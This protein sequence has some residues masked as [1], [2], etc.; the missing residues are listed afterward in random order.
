MK[1]K[2]Y[3]IF[4]GLAACLAGI[5]LLGQVSR[6]SEESQIV[7][8]NRQ[9]EDNMTEQEELK[10]IYRQVNQAMVDKDTAGLK[11]LLKEGTLLI[12]MTGYRQPVSE[13]L[14]QIESE[15]MK[16]YSWQEEVIKDI[17]IDGNRASLVGQSRVKAR[18]W[19]SGPHTW[20]LQMKVEF[21]KVDGRWLISK[22]EAST[23]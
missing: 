16:Y 1:V 13:W 11:T 7:R 17:R 8:I 2:P 15:E 23:Y 21:E 20:P 12:H 6:G 18:I 3:L 5:Y 10:R 9:K 19:G 4:L 14:D 22:Q